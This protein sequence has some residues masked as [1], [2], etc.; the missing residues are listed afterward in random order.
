M[1]WPGTALVSGVL[2]ES[3]EIAP[4]TWYDN[5]YDPDHFAGLHRGVYSGCRLVARTDDRIEY[6]LGVRFLGATHWARATAEFVPP[7]SVTIRAKGIRGIETLTRW[8]IEPVAAG[9]RVTCHYTLSLPPL[10]RPFA[11]I[12]RRLYERTNRRIW[13][14]DVPALLRIERLKGLGYVDA[15]PSPLPPALAAQLAKDAAA[16][17]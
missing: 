8:Q 10:L 12:L 7:D 15:F 17:A 1:T 3:L 16:D 2:S 14:E 5:F 4:L 9:T 6:D 13:R 11:P